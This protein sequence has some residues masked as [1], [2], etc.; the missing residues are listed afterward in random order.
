MAEYTIR[1]YGDSALMIRF[2]Q[3]IAPDVLQAVTALNNRITAMR[4]PG[5]LDTIPAYASL[6]VV[7]D[8]AV[9]DTGT[10]AEVIRNTDTAGDAGTAVKQR[11]V[12][13]PVLY[14]VPFP[15]DLKAVAGHAGISE[16]E[17]IALHTS[18]TYPVYMIGFLPGFP[19]LGNLNERIH[20]PRRRK[21]RTEIPAGS[22][23]IGGKQTGIYPLTSPGGWH[24]IGK[25]PVKLYDPEREEPVL[26]RTGDILRFRAV[27][28]EEYKAIEEAGGALCISE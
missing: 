27:S 14:G 12:E 20:T 11:T 8:P 15:E 7:F 18:G 26:L 22:V 25:T 9:T 13:I 5:V 2:E 21:P 28:E 3:R 10:L 23:G 1:P 19:Y 17:V 16:E 24:I 4:I 6:T